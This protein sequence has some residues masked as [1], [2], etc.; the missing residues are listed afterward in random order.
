MISSSAPPPVGD[1]LEVDVDAGVAVGVSGDGTSAPPSLQRLVEQYGG[2]ARDLLPDELN[3]MN[4]STTST[5]ELM[6]GR[7]Q[8]STHD[9]SGLENTARAPPRDTEEEPAGQAQELHPGNVPPIT[10]VR[11]RSARKGGLPIRVACTPPQYLLE[12]HNVLQ[13][14]R[15]N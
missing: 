13:G 15:R 4:A 2:Q 1:Y 10:I 7:V 5:S 11:H 3:A 12:D 9:V 14:N 6:A 8:E